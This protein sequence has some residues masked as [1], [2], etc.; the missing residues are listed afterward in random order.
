VIEK[1]RGKFLLFNYIVLNVIEIAKNKYKI[2][3]S[4]LKKKFENHG[5]LRLVEK[6]LKMFKTD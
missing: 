1:N 6:A 4:Q 2:Q 3:S 5:N